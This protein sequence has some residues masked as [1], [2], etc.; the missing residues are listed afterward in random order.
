MV[1]ARCAY[2]DAT[3][4]PNSMYCVSCGQ[5]VMAVV[6]PE[7]VAEA[8]VAPARPAAST[9]SAASAEAAPARAGDVPLPTALPW[10]ASRAPRAGAGHAR[11]VV[12]ERVQLVLPGGQRVVLAGRALIGRK[13]G[14]EA[15]AIGAQAIEVTDAQR[16]VSR[17][18][19]SVALE[20]GKILV[21]DA[22][23]SNGS[24]I[25]RDG[26]AHP[27]QSGGAQQEAVP[28]D[29]LVLGDVRIRLE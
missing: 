1:S 15:L 3:L 4:Q 23:S 25:E 8:P 21:S 18:H 11:S 6:E 29:V 26:H 16:S 24:A 22:G 7:P 5:L 28:G 9:A 20:G 14:R 10:Q 27:L 2:C 13:P 19:L 12:V 17:V